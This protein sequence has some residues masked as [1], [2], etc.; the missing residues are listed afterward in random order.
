[1]IITYPLVMEQIILREA[2]L[3]KIRPF[4]DSQYI[5]VITG[6]RRCGKSELLKQI[7]AELR[8]RGILESQIICL[9]LEGVSGEGITTRKKLEKALT[10]KIIT[11][12]KYYIFI[13]EIQ[14]VKKFEVAIASIRV[15]FN[16]SLFVTGSNSKLLRGKLQDRLTGRAKEFEIHPF[17]YSEVLEYKKKNGIPLSSD[18]FQDY[19]Q[20][21]GMPQ[22]FEEPNEDGTREYLLSLYQSIVKKDVFDQHKRIN[23]TWFKTISDY[24]MSNSGS[25]FSA[26]SLAK[27]LKDQLPKNKDPRSEAATISQYADYLLECYFLS[28]CRP[29]YLKG[30]A[31]LKGVRKFYPVDVGLKNALSTG[32]QFDESFALEGIVFNELVYRGY[33]VRYGKLRDG[34]IDFVAFKGK[35]KCLIQV[36]DRITDQKTFDREYGA[37]KNIDDASPKYVFSLDEKDTSNNGITHLN[38][39]DFL[40]GKTDIVIL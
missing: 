10:K 15:S 38:I 22:R 19:L 17:T 12:E 13:D 18:D 6:I 26:L 7:M 24:V 30:K 36:A 21:G 14:H 35:K 3:E 39:I 29:Y 9:D 20:W 33:S 27:Y 34:E 5:K 11:K 1:M 23:K 37:F 8:S 16:C 32:I 2:Y 28:E 40:L 31:A 25:L 4:Y